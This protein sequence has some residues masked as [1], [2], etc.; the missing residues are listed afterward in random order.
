M[1]AGF[2][3]A[4]LLL[5]LALAGT[6]LADDVVVEAK[7]LLDG[8]QAESA[9]GL[10][11]PLEADRAG[12]PDFDFV[13]GMA[14]I[15]SGRIAEAIFALQRVVDTQPENGPARAE[16]G[17]ALM[18]ANETDA[19]KAELETVRSLDPPEEVSATIDR[20]LA[21]IER[22]QGAYRTSFTRYVEAGIGFD[23]NINAATEADQVAAPALGGLVFA[24]ASDSRE[25]SSGILDLGAG[26]AFN[27]PLRPDL[28][29]TG[30][31]DFDYRITPQDSDFSYTDARGNAGLEYTRGQDRF[32]VGVQAS[33]FFVDAASAGTSADRELGGASVQWQHVF[34]ATTQ[35][36][37]FGQAALIRYPDQRSRN[38]NRYIGGIGVAHALPDVAYRPVLFASAFAGIENAQNDRRGIGGGKHFGRDL[39]GFRVGGQGQIDDRSTVYGTFTYQMSDYDAPDPIFASTRDDD[40]FAASA[41]YRFQYDNNWSVT[42]QINYTNNDSNLVVTDY[43]RFEIMVMIRNDF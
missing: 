24:L 41:G 33:K 5:T 6:S 43:E 1:R 38:V 20:Y 8:G 7:S 11:K 27:S 9:Y 28:R 26:F 12:E 18:L 16:L 19:A 21:S 30:G 15:D 13:L 29:F 37:V 3:L 10:L 17:R 14:A 42:P 25:Q 23:D 39:Y 34:G 4:V 36:N 32:S 31:I 40:F 35:A 2:D 22:Y